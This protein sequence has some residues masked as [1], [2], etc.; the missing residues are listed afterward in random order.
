MKF[1]ISHGQQVKEQILR[2]HE[3]AK[4]S[5]IEAEYVRSLKQIVRHLEEDPL[6]WGDPEY[7]LKHEESVVCHGIV[8]PL[9]ARFAVFQVER[10]VHIIEI[11]ALPGSPLSGL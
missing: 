4:K 5:A 1:R 2:L 11:R 6:G 8:K 3:S 10:V 9:V 7:N